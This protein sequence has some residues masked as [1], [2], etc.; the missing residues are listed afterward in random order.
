MKLTYM[1]QDRNIKI[2]PHSK[3]ILLTYSEV[4]AVATG[5]NLALYFYILYSKHYAMTLFQQ[6]IKSKV[7]CS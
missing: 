6:M 4:C 1:T 5:M 2:V 7:T 3:L